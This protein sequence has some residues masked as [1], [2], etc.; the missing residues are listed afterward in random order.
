MNKPKEQEIPVW[1]PEQIQDG[2]PCKSPIQ[3]PEFRQVTLAHVDSI[4]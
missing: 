2:T 4:T 1:P 3:Y